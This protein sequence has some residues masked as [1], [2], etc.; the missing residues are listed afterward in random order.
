MLKLSLESINYHAPYNI[1]LSN[2]G[3]FSFSTDESHVY[4]IGFVEDHMISVDNAYQFLSC[5]NLP[6]MYS[7]MRKYA[8]Q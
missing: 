6:L 2:D 8:R 7:K 5:Q 1:I 3:V 4:E